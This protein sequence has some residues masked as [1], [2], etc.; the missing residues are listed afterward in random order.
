VAD[1]WQPVT[2]AEASNEGPRLRALVLDLGASGFGARFVAPGQ[3][4]KARIPGEVGETFLALANAPG[5]ERFELLVQADET[6]SPTARALF[7]LATGDRLEIAAPAGKGFGVDAQRGRDLL[8]FAGGSGISAIR[9]VA[10]HVARHR[11][12]FGRVL[13]FFG[14]RSA[15]DL[16]Y[17]AMFE[18]WKSARIEVEPTLSRAA[19]DW[20]GR[21]GYVTAALAALGPDP[22]N[23]SA[24]IAGGK[25]FTVAVT[26][27]LERIGL[28]KARIFRNF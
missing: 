25:E 5:D 10:E 15:D 17:R 14:V 18:R 1:D 24:F 23:A 27:S 11:D 19:G 26:Q 7:R 21:T 12:G 16:A 28:D 22:K 8:L 4:V 2:V 20:R 6:S 9:S 3:Y 13:L